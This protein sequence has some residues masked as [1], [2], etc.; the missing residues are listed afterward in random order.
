MFYIFNMDQKCSEI[1]L[2]G[3]GVADVMVTTAADGT[4][5][6][7]KVIQNVDP[8]LSVE[9]AALLKESA[10]L[11]NETK[12]TFA[13]ISSLTSSLMM[14]AKDFVDLSG[15]EKKSIVLSA[16]GHLAVRNAPSANDATLNTAF[17]L[18]AAGSL[19]D[20]L[21]TVAKGTGLFSTTT[22]ATTAT[23]TTTT[24]LTKKT[25]MSC[26]GNPVD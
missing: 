21:Y 16:I 19:I 25:N 13:N 17:C 2:D 26:C 22:T 3:D 8:K 9:A 5:I 24:T 11:I 12:V 6:N 7:S 18:N 15:E 20:T 23:T 1:D 10:D 14:K 4:I